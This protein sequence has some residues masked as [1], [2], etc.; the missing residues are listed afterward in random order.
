M[1]ILLTHTPEMRA[2]YYGARAL[3]GLET[4]AQVALHAQ[5]DAMSPPELIA[6]ARDVDVIIADRLTTGPT[7]IFT[8]LPNLKAFVRCAVDIR[9]VDVSA[10]SSAGVL[11]THARPGFVESVAEL[12]LGY[13]VD[14]A[15]GISRATSDYRAGRNPTAQMGRQLSGSTIGIIGYG[16][17]GRYLAS[18]SAALGMK[19]LVSDPHAVVDGDDPRLAQVT[20][21]ELLTNADHVVCLAVATDATENLMNAAAFAKMKR[22]AV[23]INASRGNLVDE[24]A[25]LDALCD[26]TIA[27]AAMDV[28]RALDQM[29]TPALAARM[30]VIATPHIGG[31]TPPAIE[32][33]ALDTVEQVREL[34][35]GQVPHGS[36]NADHWTRRL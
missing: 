12:T 1:K 16:S 17:I 5:A 7:E 33:Q 3:G 19:V 9:N 21:N 35:D 29:P 20:L 36:V 32:A 24:G 26:K 15:R 14:L 23:F 11:V 6:A 8:S 25:L 28:G 10:A 27:G 13:L 18:I 2:N 22:D 4:M 30:D 31:L 34:A